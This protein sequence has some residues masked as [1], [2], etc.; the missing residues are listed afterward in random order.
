VDDAIV[1]VEAVQ[2]QLELGYSPREATQRAMDQV[3]GPIIAIG[4]VLSFV[5]FPCIFISGV[6]GAFFKQ[7]AVTIAAATLISTFNSLSLS[8]ALCA[9]LLRGP[10]NRSPRRGWQ[11][12]LLGLLAP[13]RL[14]NAAFQ[15][16]F[17]ASGRG[18][19]RLVGGLLRVPL[20]V[21]AAYLAIL[22]SGYATWCSLP[23]GF[24]PQQD[25]GYLICSIQLPDTASAERT[26]HVISQISRI[27]LNLEL[28]DDQ[29]NKVKPI[30]HVNAVAGNSFVLSAYGSNFGS[31]FVILESFERRRSAQLSADAVAAALRREFARQAPEALVNVFGAPAVP[32]LGRAGGFRI[33]IEDRGDV[34]PEA[35]QGQTDNFIEKA[36]QQKQL[37]G[38]FTVFKANSPQWFVHVDRDAC[39]ARGLE[40]GLVYE[41]LQATL[42]N[43]YV[44]DFNRFGR[45]W[46]VNVQAEPHLRDQ[47][48]DIQRL[49]VRNRWG[50]MVP[51]GAVL[52]VEERTGPLVITRYNMYPAATVNGTIAP[53]VSTGEAIELVEKLAQQELPSRLAYE[54]TELTFLEKQSRH[55][56]L[57]VFALSVVFVFLVLA[58]L[59]ES[60]WFPLV[61]MLVVPVGVASSLWGV[62]LTDPASAAATVQQWQATSEWFRPGDWFLSLA[63]TLDDQCIAPL[64][65]GVT[66]LGIRKQDVNIFT[67]VGFVVLVGLACKNA[68]LLVEYARAARQRGQSRR[69]AVLEACQL[70]YRPILMTSAAFMFGVLP[71]AAAQGA[72]AEIRQAIG[73]AVL[74]GMLGV[75]FFGILFTPVWFVV[76][77]W[78]TSG[79]GRLHRALHRLSKLLWWF[80]GVGLVRWLIQQGYRKMIQQ[81][82]RWR[83]RLAGVRA[84]SRQRSTGSSS[85][86]IPGSS[87]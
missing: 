32:R 35:L 41:T 67:Q 7:F 87:P 42:G 60:W 43:R 19:V 12:W 53:G 54:W 47:I 55:T 61:V 46:Q 74:G 63:R 17:R 11:R 58:A 10:T 37:V 49:R 8:P 22:G 24:I 18:Y 38:L 82:P 86:T 77:D 70:R 9:L 57:V 23:L 6:V 36:N 40:L 48:E 44:N 69:Q 1:V 72:G 20:L 71:L 39:A 28:E 62:W 50:Q 30:R 84:F 83:Q 75:T 45:T 56:G 80:S 76:V 31:M 73:V 68:I 15:A 85:P 78:L 33:M 65:R 16:L 59:Y 26:R 81:Y 27:A 34:G 25:K 3:T 79:E 14:V 64:H 52:R 29:G 66:A 2:H 21:L 51:L 4:F 5:F 13:W